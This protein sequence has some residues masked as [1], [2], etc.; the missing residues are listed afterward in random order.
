MRG[1]RPRSSRQIT[2][3]AEWRCARRSAQA[4]AKSCAGSGWFVGARAVLGRRGHPVVRVL[5]RWTPENLTTI[6]PVRWDGVPVV[7]RQPSGR[8]LDMRDVAARRKAHVTS[9]KAASSGEEVSM[10]EVIPFPRAPVEGT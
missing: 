7:L 10:A 9:V 1:P 3:L 8:D 5:L 6:F 4:L 2:D